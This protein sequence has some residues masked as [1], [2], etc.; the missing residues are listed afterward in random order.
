MQVV[1]VK[2]FRALSPQ[3]YLRH[4]LF[5]LLFPLMLYF[6]AGPQHIHFGMKL[7]W[8]ANVFLYPFSRYAYEAVVDYIVG[9]T[10]WLWPGVFALLGKLV[11]MAACWGLALFMAPG[12]IAYLYFRGA[13]HA[14]ES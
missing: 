2:A 13:F 7:V 4:F 10:L 14:G 11:T 6:T 3:V 8:A 9:D 12:A 5:G 1:L